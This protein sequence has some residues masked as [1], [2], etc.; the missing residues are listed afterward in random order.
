VPALRAYSGVRQRGAIAQP[1][2]TL[3]LEILEVRLARSAA[4]VRRAQKVALFHVSSASYSGFCR[5]HS[6]GKPT[7]RHSAVGRSL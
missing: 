4:D 2:L 7:Y 3:G 5:G 6:G 1:A